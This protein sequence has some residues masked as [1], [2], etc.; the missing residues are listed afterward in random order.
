MSDS[1]TPD[2]S[3]TDRGSDAQTTATSH[4]ELLDI[5]TDRERWRVAT[6][7]EIGVLTFDGNTILRF[8]VRNGSTTLELN[9]QSDEDGPVWSTQ[10]HAIEVQPT[11]VGKERPNTSGELAGTHEPWREL[12]DREQWM[13]TAV[14]NKF[15]CAFAGERLLSFRVLVDGEE[16]DFPLTREPEGC[17]WYNGKHGIEVQ[18]VVGASDLC[19]SC[20]TTT[21]ERGDADAL[22][23]DD[24]EVAE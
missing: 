23:N 2:N 18:V 11:V 3:G 1:D 21:G 7:D 22:S 17:A 13:V 8:R 24:Q 15:N 19:R 14:E 5:V 6:D 4:T 9:K 10:H 12:L 16:P 20:D